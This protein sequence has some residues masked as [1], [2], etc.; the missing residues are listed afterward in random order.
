MTVTGSTQNF[1]SS[2]SEIGV[3]PVAEQVVTEI[4]LIEL[5]D[6][7]ATATDPFLL[8]AIFP[9]IDD[10]PDG[11]TDSIPGFT[12]TPMVQPFSFDDFNAAEF[13]AGQLEITIVN[14]MVITLGSPVVIQ[15]QEIVGP[16]TLDIAG[17]SVSFNSLIQTSQSAIETMDLTGI[18]LPGDIL[19]KVSGTSVGTSGNP[20]M[21]NQ[22]A[23]ESSFVTQIGASN[24]TVTSADAPDRRQQSHRDLRRC[25]DTGADLQRKWRVALTS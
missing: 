15:F 14:D 1:S 17:A 19:V 10:I 25:A 5:D 20:V 3:D 12:I 18:T 6:I 9:D 7:P 13:S 16:D 4:G 24:L 8:N 23:R 21:I 22:G 11:L 2:F